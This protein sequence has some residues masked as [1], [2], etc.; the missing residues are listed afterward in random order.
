MPRGSSE[1]GWRWLEVD[2]RWLDLR[3]DGET[4]RSLPRLFSRVKWKALAG[5]PGTNCS[6]C[7][8]HQ[9]RIG[10]RKKETTADILQHTDTYRHTKTYTHTHTHSG[11]C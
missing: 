1:G 8:E 11:F 7:R 4:R 2:L 3:D 10:G 5:W 9:S 6:G